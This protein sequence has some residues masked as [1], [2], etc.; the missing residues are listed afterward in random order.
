MKKT[1]ILKFISLFLLISFPQV[2]FTGGWVGSG[3]ELF[4][5]GHNPWFL[6]NVSEVK[7]CILLD[8]AGVSA[9]RT[10][11]ESSLL[12][13]LSYWKYEFF[14]NVKT[15]KGQ[16]IAEIGNQEFKKIDD[17]KDADLNFKFGFN[18]L[19]KEEI[20]YLVKPRSYVGITVR[21][22]YSPINLRGK[23]FIFISSDKGDH[24]FDNPG[25]LIERPWQHK[26]L[27]TYALIHELGHV[28]GLPHTGG[29]I[30][31]EVFMDQLLHKKMS[32]YYLDNPIISFMRPPRSMSVC[33]KNGEF[34]HLFFQVSSNT[35]CIQLEES[36]EAGGWKISSLE[37]AG[38]TPQ[39]IGQVKALKL[40][41]QIVSSKPAI[42]IHLTTEQTVFSAMER[43]LNSFMI[44]PVITNFN[45]NGIYTSV[46]SHRPISVKL[47]IQ[48]ESFV[49]TGL[50]E[51]KI[52]Q[53]FVYAPPTL[54]E[55]ISPL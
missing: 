15:Q 55:M 52:T 44:G 49:I 8:E 20:T 50:V 34:N 53:V 18:T 2:G 28:F 22:D 39:W 43:L 1:L 46:G 26:K 54:L 17:C 14:N 9:D 24:S 27:L 31:S 35:A 11:I 38:A 37:A 19:T 51:N 29:G 25:H 36:E 3:G 42:L 41:Q 6:R 7:Y 16:F 48:P 10:T 47:D 5:D 30:M 40:G 21:T 33:R 12:E 32:S 45:T 4:R 23:G 13:A